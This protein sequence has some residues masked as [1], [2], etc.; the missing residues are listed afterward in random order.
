MRMPRPR[1]PGCARAAT[2]PWRS[3]S[4]RRSRPCC[5]AWWHSTMPTNTARHSSISA[6]CSASCRPRSADDPRKARPISK[7]PLSIRKGATCSQRWSTRAITRA[8][9]STAS[10]TIVYCARCWT[11]TPWRQATP[12]AAPWHNTR[13]DNCWTSPPRISRNDHVESPLHS[14]RI[15]DVE[16]DGRRG[17]YPQ[18]RHR[19]PRR[20]ELDA[21][22]A[23]RRRRDRQAHPRRGEVPF[24]PGRRDGQRQERA[25]QDPHRPIAGRRARERRA[26]RGLSGHCALQ[27]PLRLSQLPR[28]RLRARAHGSR[29][30]QRSR[31]TRLR[32]F[33]FQRGG[34]AYLMSNQ[35][36]RSLDDLKG[37]KVWV[38]EDDRIS[39][40]AVE[41][42][43]V[44]PIPLPL[45]DVLPGLQTGLIDTIAGSPVGV[46]A[47]QWQPQ[48]KYL[49]DEP[50]VY[51]YATMAIDR[52]AF[53]RISPTD[54]AVVREVRGG[55]F[56]TRDQQNRKDDASA[57]DA[58]KKQG[59]KF[60]TP[61][62]DSL[63]RENDIRAEVERRLL[64]QRI[65]SPE[66][67]QSLKDHL[68]KQ[69]KGAAP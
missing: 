5:N 49:V 26:H 62:S 66:L 58:L 18:D 68:A 22:A 59:I 53:D 32:E 54:Q 34:F 40:I 13:R 52:K 1:P 28:N 50:L 11:P 64:Q 9:S 65:L 46:I 37:R 44:T 39:R 56:R 16:P 33:R 60:V 23:Q 67:I 63:Q 38:P 45:T 61:T 42:V 20:H 10:C 29:V 31:R 7:R 3:P 51:L 55:V 41:S 57:R 12:S 24:L 35:P 14:R 4:C 8:S 17:H 19:R 6:S 27:H 2:S 47:L 43:G 36:V 25:A 69:R 48:V 21:G 30:D 15:V